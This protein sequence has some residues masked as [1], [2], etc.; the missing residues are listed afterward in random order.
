MQDLRDY[1]FLETPRDL[2]TVTIRT[3]RPDDGPKVRRAFQGLE[4]ETLYSRFFF[5]K[6][7]LS[8][9]ELARITRPDS[10]SSVALLATTTEGENEI[11][12]GGASYVMLDPVDLERGAEVAFLVEE[13]YQGRGVASALMRHLTVIARMRGLAR[14]SP[15]VLARNRAMLRTFRGCGLR[16]TSRQESEVIRVTLS[17]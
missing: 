13:D 9:S 15:E 5:Y 16:M 17:L 11:V 14:L 6:T 7:D 2:V 10:G 8:D 3:V 4:Q 12:V 1:S